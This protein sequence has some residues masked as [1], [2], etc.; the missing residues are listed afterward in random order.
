MG[1]PTLPAASGSALCNVESHYI[2]L[3]G[4]LASTS[5]YLFTLHFHPI[6]DSKLLIDIIA[7]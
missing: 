1:I 3:L 2:I 6:P 7:P 5:T 4:L